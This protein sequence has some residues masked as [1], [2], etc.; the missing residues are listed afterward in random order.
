MEQVASHNGKSGEKSGLEAN[1]SAEARR[2]SLS[3][4]ECF[5]DLLRHERCWSLTFHFGTGR[6][7]DV[8]GV[9]L[10]IAMV[11]QGIV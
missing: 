9:C 3:A 5:Y 8:D 4:I 10:F 6:R 7:E 1:T 2:E 11:G